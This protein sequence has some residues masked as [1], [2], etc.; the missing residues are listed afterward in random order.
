MYLENH[1]RFSFHS[2]SRFLLSL[3]LTVSVIGCGFHLKQSA[4]IAASFGPVSIEGTGTQSDLY[5][6]M[7]NILKQSDIQ[8]TGADAAANRIVISNEK[9]ERKVLSVGS[10]GKVSEYELIKS[11]AF[12]VIKADGTRSI[13]AQNLAVNRFYSVNDTDVLS[14]DF[15][16]RDL[17]RLMDEELADR[18]FRYIGA[19]SR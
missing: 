4:S 5:R 15:E 11:L 9:N 10:N 2:A 18:M 13:E 7:R 17:R 19:K 3:L 12:S 16:E 14:E 1:D 8:I 6:A